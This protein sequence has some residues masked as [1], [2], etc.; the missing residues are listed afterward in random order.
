L[1]HGLAAETIEGDNVYLENA[2]V[3]VVRGGDVN[4]G[5]GCLIGAVEYKK[6]FHKD[7]SSTVRE[8]KKV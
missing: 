1:N 5:P 8:S 6:N 2:T 4:I 3:K 7:G